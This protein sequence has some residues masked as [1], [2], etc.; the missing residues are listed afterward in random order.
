M[1][2][3]APTPVRTPTQPLER[4]LEV[5]SMG[6]RLT[7]RVAHGPGNEALAAAALAAVAARVQCWA[8]R[9]TR[10]TDTSDLAA[11]N[12]DPARPLTP[13]RPTLAAVLDWA[14][15]ATDR[16][17]G[18]LDVTL[19]DER[20][21][22]QRPDPLPVLA[23]DL[24]PHRW[25]L[26]RRP[27]GA[28]VHRDAT[29]RFDTDGVAKGWIAD[30]ALELL[31]RWPAV[32]VDA[33]GDIAMRPAPDTEW[34]IGIAD[35]RPDAEHELAMLRF[36]DRLAGGR[37]AVATSGTSVHRWG[38]E[39]DGAP[40][41]HLLDPLTR[42]PAITDVV[43]ATVISTSAREAEVLAKSALIAGSDAGFDLL[44]RSGARGA[45]LLLTSGETIALPRTME[46]L[47]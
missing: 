4:A 8:A 15:R 12:L 35:P 46:W 29:F 31:R 43:Q 10:Y 36:D 1:T 19:L 45:V 9:L 2:A 24:E 34:F 26:E 14:E 47:A 13:V 16:A 18:Y 28:I 42:R 3:A 27:R 5:P 40:R 17:E 41:H 30:R 20:L 44:E 39:P 38:Q 7:L 33:D 25:W 6:G 11:L 21:A 37:V 22:L 32:L 23:A